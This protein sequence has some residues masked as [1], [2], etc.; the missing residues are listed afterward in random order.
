MFCWFVIFMDL[1][2]NEVLLSV[3]LPYKNFFYKILSSLFLWSNFFS[4]FGYLHILG[5]L[6][7]TCI[8]LRRKILTLNPCIW[9]DQNMILMNFLDLFMVLW[10]GSKFEFLENLLFWTKTQKLHFL[11][12][13]IFRY[14][15]W[16]QMEG[17]FLF[18][19]MS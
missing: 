18:T 14:F 2:N 1:V 17:I 4:K 7:E 8:F 15:I 5:E 11:E 13:W 3:W 9:F 6:H 10:K 12:F 19:F 16:I